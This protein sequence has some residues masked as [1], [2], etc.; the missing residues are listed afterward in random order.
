MFAGTTPLYT[1]VLHE[2]GHALGFSNFFNPAT[3]AFTGSGGH[4]DTFSRSL[5]DI[6]TGEYWHQMSDGERLASAINDPNLVWAGANVTAQRPLF[7]GPAPEVEINAPPAIAGTHPA[8]LGDEPNAGI[9]PGGMTAGV[10]DGDS[11]VTNPCVQVPPEEDDNFPGHIVLYDLPTGCSAV[12][13]ALLADFA[14]ASGVIIRNTAAS[15]LPNISGQIVNQDI[16]IPYVGV[17]QSVGDDLRAQI[18][19]ANATIQES[20]DVLNGDNT[21]MLRMFAPAAFVQGSSV[22]HWASEA[23]PDLLMESARG[24]LAYD[25]VDLT[26]AAMADIGW[27]VNYPGGDPVIIFDDGFEDP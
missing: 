12:L 23:R 9:P 13:A 2:L 6:E 20:A 7:L 27:S 10:I 18:A 3:G 24:T 22:G 14:G 21:G 25:Q 8:V 17:E 5:F 16:T 26:V 4:P 11:E 15:G 19:L 1:V